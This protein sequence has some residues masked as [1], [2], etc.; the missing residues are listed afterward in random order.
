[1]ALFV[2]AFAVG[3][4][5]FKNY[6][7]SNQSKEEKKKTHSIKALFAEESSTDKL[8]EAYEHQ[9]LKVLKEVLVFHLMTKGEAPT[10]PKKFAHILGGLKGAAEKRK[11]YSTIKDSLT[12]MAALN[13][14]FIYHP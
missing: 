7:N 4:Y 14:E 12:R 10:S 13:R 1:M 9:L 6:S 8:N 3:S 11:A 5:Y 2:S